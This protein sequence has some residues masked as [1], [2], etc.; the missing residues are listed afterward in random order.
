M[1]K[2]KLLNGETLSLYKC[3]ANSHAILNIWFY[4]GRY[5][6]GVVSTVA[7]QQ[8]GSRFEPASCQRAFSSVAVHRLSPIVSWDWSHPPTPTGLKG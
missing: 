4:S 3:H 2:S 8:D 6:S 1:H 7:T 5:G